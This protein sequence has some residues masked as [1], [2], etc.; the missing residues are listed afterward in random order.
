MRVFQRLPSNNIK[1]NVGCCVGDRTPSA[2]HIPITHLMCCNDVHSLLML[3]RLRSGF[4]VEK[5]GD[6]IELAH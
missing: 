5:D 3:D 4:P 1:E 6:L 2:V